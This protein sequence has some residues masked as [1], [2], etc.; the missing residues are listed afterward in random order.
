MSNGS[1]ASREIDGFGIFQARNDP[2]VVKL[3]VGGNRQDIPTRLVVFEMVRRGEELRP[4]WSVPLVTKCT[5]YTSC[6]T[7]DGRFC[8]TLDEMV[9]FGLDSG[10]VWSLTEHAVVVYD[11]LRETHRAWSLEDLFGSEFMTLFSLSGGV[12]GLDWFSDVS[13]L[14]NDYAFYVH[15]KLKGNKSESVSVLKVDLL[16]QTIERR[17]VADVERLGDPEEVQVQKTF[18]QIHWG[19]RRPGDA[20]DSIHFEFVAGKEP[21]ELFADCSSP[22][23]SAEMK[24]FLGGQTRLAYRWDESRRI[25]VLQK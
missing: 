7:S 3:I 23:L 10:P 16:D 2:R 1:V 14:E 21:R 5:P 4:K 24:D 22:L 8:V 17:S 18:G 20:E 9:P 13:L 15:L 11:L 12:P 19:F 6:G 25:Y